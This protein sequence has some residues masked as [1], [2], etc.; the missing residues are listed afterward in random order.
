MNTINVGLIGCGFMGKAHSNAYRNVGFFFPDM[1]AK[2][3]R[4]LI[5]GIPEPALKKAAAEFGW[6]EYET[7]FQKVIERDDIDVVDITTPNFLHCEEVIQAAEAG[8]H[9]YCEKPIAMSVAE[10]KQMVEAVTKA[11]VKHTVGFNYRRCPA[12]SLMKQMIAE[13]KI[14]QIYHFRG[15]YLQDWITDPDF[16][17]VWRLTKEVSGSGAHGDLNAHLI[18]LA[19]YL[20]GEFDEVVAMDKIFIKERPMVVE[21]TGLSGQGSSK[22]GKVTVDDAMLFMANFKNGAVGSFEATRFATGRKNHNRIEING[23]KGS[24]VWC[25]ED[26]NYV[27][28]FSK[29]D[30]ELNQGFRSI[31]ATEP[32]HPY[33]GA[34]WPPGH[35][36]G[37]EHTFINQVYDFIT[38]VAT[39][40]EII[41]DMVDGL[42]CQE[43]LEAVSMSC[44]ER[45]WVKIAE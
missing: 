44:Q 43:V 5:C 36:L 32:D 31:I 10:G 38:A 39:D 29:E 18:D 4:K 17:L 6:E 3:V 1:A 40:G 12:V 30:E 35:I 28:F 15:A 33:A 26:M 16:P 8:K 20:V 14:G 2:P 34:Y 24:L 13:G 9:I 27:Q 7:D 45:G 41:P 11:G 21:S 37:Y 42:R 22:K 25:F 19:R 23:S